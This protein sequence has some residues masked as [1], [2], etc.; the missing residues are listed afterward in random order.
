MNPADVTVGWEQT[1]YTVSEDVG[2]FQAYYSVIFPT[3]IQMIS[4]PFFMRV[5]TVTGTAGES[6][7]CVCMLV[8]YF[9]HNTTCIY[10][11][12]RMTTNPYVVVVRNDASLIL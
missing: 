12:M 5:A 10:I 1:S 2:T 6:L 8:N 9:N 3:N 4:N 7:F 11:Q